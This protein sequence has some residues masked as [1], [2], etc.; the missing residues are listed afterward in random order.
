MSFPSILFA[1]Y[2]SQAHLQ[3]TSD[4]QHP[5]GQ[6]MIYADGRKFAY[7]LVGAADLIAGDAIQGKAVV[8]GDYTAVVQEVAAAVGD[9]SISITS[10]T[11]TAA[12]YY[13][14][15]WVHYNKVDGLGN[16]YKLAATNA[17]ILLT[18]GAGDIIQL[19]PRDPI[20][21]ATVATSEVGLIP[22]EFNGVIQAII[23]LATS[24]IVGV[25]QLD[26]TLAQYGFVQTWGMGCLQGAASQVV[27]HNNNYVGAA[28]G[29]GGVNIVDTDPI[30]GL[31]L[32]I[33][34]AGEMGALF[35]TID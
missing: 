18:S 35:I 13:D 10:T 24:R 14:G 28:A 2:G 23:T 8:S 16:T 33:P 26:V 31:N 15:G 34:A 9:T 5:L 20:R 4:K 1:D 6:R 29:R 17:N 12:A 22:D 30:L 11:T 7:C 25:A 21:V 27:S 19:D 32:S 3:D